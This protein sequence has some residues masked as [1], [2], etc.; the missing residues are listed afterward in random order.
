MKPL[1]SHYTSVC[2]KSKSEQVFC[3]NVKH[4]SSQR[5]DVHGQSTVSSVFSSDNETVIMLQ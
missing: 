2:D 4:F 3:S 5:S 1:T